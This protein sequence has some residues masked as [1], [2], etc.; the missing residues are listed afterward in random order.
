M[1]K[2]ELQKNIALYYSKLPTKAQE[3]FASMEWLR[4]L[5]RIAVKYG[6]ND[7]QKE[8]LGTET[9]LVI[10]GVIHL[11]EYEEK[12]TNELALSKESVDNMLVEINDLILKDIITDIT[13]TFN[14]NSE[15]GTEEESEIAPKLD[16][17]FE[18]LPPNIKKIVS[19]S[20]YQ[21]AL[22]NISKEYN[23]N[24]T[25]MGVLDKA[26]TDLIIGDLGPERF[27]DSLRP[28]I[29]L[30]P[31]KLTKLVNDVNEKIFRR[32]RE[33]IMASSGRQPEIKPETKS[34]PA[35]ENLPIAPSLGGENT[36]LK[37]A[38]IHIQNETTP[39]LDKLELEASVKL[40]KEVRP[41]LA[42][43]LSG[44]VGN[45]IKETEH[46]ID[47]S[48]KK[49]GLKPSLIQSMPTPPPPKVISYPKG[50]DPYRLPPE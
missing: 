19:E 29:G 36:V 20:N 22:Y 41:I 1:D 39:V 40:N 34:A 42:Q 13:N 12:L 31:E 48:V 26:T 25:Q 23:L 9:T 6:L 15:V 50:G 4:T 43:K 11:V 35:P 27:E 44:Y 5:E 46:S 10:L 47:N 16:E 24:V 49:D 8:I 7:K 32:I 30:E 3:V 21:D 17:R 33:K 45:E 37:K 2:N 14:K 18:K 38:G 28:K